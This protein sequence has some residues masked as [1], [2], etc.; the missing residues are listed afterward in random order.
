MRGGG[1][2][3]VHKIINRYELTKSDKNA[4]IQAKKDNDEAWEEYDKLAEDY[5][6]D[7]S[8]NNSLIFYTNHTGVEG[9]YAIRT[10]DIKKAMG[11]E[12]IKKMPA[13]NIQFF[14]IE[15]DIQHA[16]FIPPSGGVDIKCYTAE[17]IN[18]IIGTYSNKYGENLSMED[19]GIDTADEYEIENY[20]FLL[21]P[22]NT[23]LNTYVMI[24]ST[25]IYDYI[26][27][28]KL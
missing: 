2:R 1:K 28:I 4:I 8:F 15:F 7:T 10:F 20:G 6:K 16:I 3:L 25:W 23:E 21:I 26:N 17:G 9:Y 19:I 13:F 22:H 5:W 27:E 14:D 18:A 12:Q 24:A 11:R